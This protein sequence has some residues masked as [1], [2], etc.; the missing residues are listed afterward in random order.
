MTEPWN[1]RASP[2]L[3]WRWI[4]RAAREGGKLTPAHWALLADTPERDG[5]GEFSRGGGAFIFS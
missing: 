1:D 2:A 5:R 4:D 3:P